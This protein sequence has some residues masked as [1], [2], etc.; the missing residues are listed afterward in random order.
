[1]SDLGTAVSV[2]R[3]DGR[4]TTPEDRAVLK[5]AIERVRNPRPDRSGPF[6]HFLFKIG[7]SW[8]RGS[9]GLFVILTQ[10]WLGDEKGNDGLDGE[11]LL[12]RDRPEAERFA[13]QLQEVLG[14]DYV[15]ER[16]CDFW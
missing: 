2:H 13:E 1:M 7:G 12:D 8:R 11:Q 16:L 4:D 6:D 5:M 9:Q 14:D 3:A 15:V 10:Y